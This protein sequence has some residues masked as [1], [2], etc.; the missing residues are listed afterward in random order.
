MRD[1]VE[2]RLLVGV[3]RGRRRSAAIDADRRRLGHAPAVA[4]SSRPCRCSNAAIIARGT[5]EPPTS[6]ARHAPR[7]P[8]AP[9]FASSSCEDP[10]PDRRHAGRPA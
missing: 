6:I 4:R 5:A 10:D 3:A 9:G 2:L 8:S 1:V 7:G